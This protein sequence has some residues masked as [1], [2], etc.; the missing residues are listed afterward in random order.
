MY[1][2]IQFFRD[3]C[4]NALL[5]LMF[6]QLCALMSMKNDFYEICN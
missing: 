3:F 4:I 6:L 5:H 1:Y 2:Y